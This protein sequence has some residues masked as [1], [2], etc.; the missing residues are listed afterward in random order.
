MTLLDILNLKK[1]RAKIFGSFYKKFIVYKMLNLNNGKIYIGLTSDLSK[2]FTSH[3][4]NARTNKRG[5]L[6][7]AAIKKHGLNKFS[8]EVIQECQTEQE[9]NDQEV[10]WIDYYKSNDL[11]LGYNLTNGGNNFKFNEE[12]KIKKRKLAKNKKEVFV[13]DKLGNFLSKYDSAAE[14]SRALGTNSTI[15][16]KAL[17]NGYLVKNSLVV[18]YFYSEKIDPHK[19]NYKKPME[20]KVPPKTFVWRLTDSRDGK[21]YEEVGIRKLALAIG[22]PEDIIRS[23]AYGRSYYK[24][25]QSFLKIEKLDKITIDKAL[26]NNE[27]DQNIFQE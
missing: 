8:F 7:S 27:P 23:I 11:L 16:F 9:M 15:I 25:Y 26:K 2:R 22:I 1:D 3:F 20:G 12:T 10:Y 18:K 5:Y 19:Y 17:K 24:E 6:I 14:C 21:T 13:Y 4:Q